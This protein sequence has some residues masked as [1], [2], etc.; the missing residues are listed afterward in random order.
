MPAIHIG[1][2]HEEIIFAVNT[3]KLVT[4]FFR[5]WKTG[6]NNYE[7]LPPFLSL[8]NL[9]LKATNGETYEENLQNVKS[10]CYKND[11]NFDQM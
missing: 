3:F 8:E 1:I 9:L 6:L 2:V 4:Y 10:S 11:I 7:F 5:N